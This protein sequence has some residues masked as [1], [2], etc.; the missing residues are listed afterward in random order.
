MGTNYTRINDWGVIQIKQIPNA[1]N[2][3][4]VINWK[5]SLPCVV[6]SG[7]PSYVAPGQ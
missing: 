6:E 4:K 2:P 1:S 7:A 5:G 3:T